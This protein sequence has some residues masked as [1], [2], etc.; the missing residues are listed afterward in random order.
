MLFHCAL[1]LKKFPKIKRQYFPCNDDFDYT[2]LDGMA[3]PLPEILFVNYKG[4][5]ISYYLACSTAV[6]DKR[7]VRTIDW[8]NTMVLALDTFR[9]RFRRGWWLIIGK[10]VDNSFMFTRK[11]SNILLPCFYCRPSTITSEQRNK[12]QKQWLV[13]AFHIP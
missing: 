5:F 1:E 9:F 4:W 7:T 2:T 10:K 11:F 12:I 13:F 3:N 8:G 6:L